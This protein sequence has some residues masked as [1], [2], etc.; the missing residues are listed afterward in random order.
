ML[1][2]HLAD[3][4]PLLLQLGEP[5]EGVADVLFSGDQAFQLVHDGLLGLHVVR[6]FLLF[7]PADVVHPLVE[8]VQQLL[9]ALVL[10]VQ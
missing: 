3:G 10:L 9:E 5:L 1:L 8:G 6:F 2:G 4:L 7:L